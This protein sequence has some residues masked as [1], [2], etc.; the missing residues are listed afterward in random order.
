MKEVLSRIQHNLMRPS[1]RKHICITLSRILHRVYDHFICELCLCAIFSSR[2]SFEVRIFGP[3]HIN[4]SQKYKATGDSF[5]RISLH[6]TIYN[7]FEWNI[8]FEISYNCVIHKDEC[9]QLEQKRNLTNKMSNKT[10]KTSDEN[11][12]HVVIV[13]IY[14]WHKI[15]NISF[16]RSVWARVFTFSV[17]IH[18]TSSPPKQHHKSARRYINSLQKQSN[19]AVNLEPPWQMTG[20]C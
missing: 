19:R 12:F 15:Q 16:Q 1:E 5:A 7:K 17:R 6:S 20:S 8:T 13:R 11:T 18:R 9:K 3:K 10:T 14:E 2:N 4:T